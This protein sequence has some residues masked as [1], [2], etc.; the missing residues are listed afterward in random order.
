MNYGLMISLKV[1]SKLELI[2]RNPQWT[3]VEELTA[4][5]RCLAESLNDLDEKP[6]VKGNIRIG[7]YILLSTLLLASLLRLLY[8]LDPPNIFSQLNES[9]TRVTSIHLC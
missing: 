8:L 3:A 6:W 7:D 5:R 4:Y 1:E 9:G 2:D